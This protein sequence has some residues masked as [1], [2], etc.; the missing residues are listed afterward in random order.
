[1]TPNYLST[2]CWVAN[3]RAWTDNMVWK[4]RGNY[5]WA[6]IRT[7]SIW[8][9]QREW[10]QNLIITLFSLPSLWQQY[11][12]I[13]PHPQCAAKHAPTHV[14]RAHSSK[15]HFTS[16]MHD[17]STRQPITV[18]CVCVFVCKRKILMSKKWTWE[19]SDVN[20][21]SPVSQ[22]VKGEQWLNLWDV[23]EV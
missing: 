23:E 13:V 16:V 17:S 18:M 15:I 20:S 11:S 4:S 21:P 19:E 14:Q 12:I 6:L 1:M 8:A 2:R 22:T 10:E 7:V 5:W 9:M 3:T